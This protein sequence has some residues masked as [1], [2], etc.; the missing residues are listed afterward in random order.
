MRG[1]GIPDPNH[2]PPRQSLFLVTSDLTFAFQPLFSFPHCTCYT[3]YMPEPPPGLTLLP[4]T[5][6]FKGGLHSTQCG[7]L[8]E[9]NIPGTAQR[10]PKTPSCSSKQEVVAVAA[11]STT[12]MERGVKIPPFSFKKRVKPPSPPLL[13]FP[14]RL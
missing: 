13:F 6:P 2:N 7:S 12:V 4:E 10:V 9:S 8:L 3:V 14:D 11:P 5:N 1:R